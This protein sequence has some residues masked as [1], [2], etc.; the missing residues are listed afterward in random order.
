MAS[1]STRLLNLSLHGANLATR[2]L[3]VFF[4]AK[5]LKPSDV[6]YYGLFTAAVGYSLYFVGLDFYAYVTREIVKTPL[7]ERGRLLKGQAALSG[8]LYL[9]FVPVA[10]AFL[11]Q[12]SGWPSHL[13]IWFL[14][15]LVLEHFNQEMSRLLIALS[16]QVSASIV[17]F[18]RQGSWALT[19]VA[20]MHFDESSRQLDVV[21]LLWTISG[22]ASALIAIS[23]LRMLGIKGWKDSLDWHWI[24]RG[25]AVSTAFLVATLALRGIQTFDRYWL[26]A[27][28]GVEVVAA[29]VLFTGVAGSLLAFLDAG[30]FSF[31]YPM[32]IKL[33][34]E[35]NI[36]LLR[37]KL[38]QT[39]GVTVMLSACFAA[40]SWFALPYL[41]QW[42]GK[43][44][45]ITAISFYPWLLLASITNAVGLVPHLALYASGQDKTIIHSHIAAFITFGVAVWALRGHSGPLAVPQ[46]IVISFFLILTWKAAACWRYLLTMQER[47]IVLQFP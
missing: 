20:I 5:Y 42:I 37:S 29:Y 47:K 45:Y 18:V 10:Y 1:M 33:S 16:E 13:L 8:I 2:F 4:L 23:K 39:L 25:I 46:G 6:G 28:G 21:M 12:Y 40:V 44:A 26:E 3:F 17:L 27:I 14:P 43:E 15:L 11:Y 36:D 19:A 30:V 22:L 24:K 35:K 38:W 32:F 41:L 31:A 34:N 9:L 7:E